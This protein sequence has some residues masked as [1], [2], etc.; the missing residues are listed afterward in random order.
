M[1]YGMFHK[2][3]PS[4]VA[5][6]AISKR[7]KEDPA[8]RARIGVICDENFAALGKFVEALSASQ[9]S[10][11]PTIT[12]WALANG[13]PAKPPMEELQQN[14]PRRAKQ[15]ADYMKSGW[16]KQHPVQIL[17]DNVEW[18]PK[19]RLVDVG[20]GLGQISIAL[21]EVLPEWSFVGHDFDSVIQRGKAAL[22]DSLKD[23]VQFMAYDFFDTQPVEG[24]DAYL[25]RPIFHNW[26]DNDCVKILQQLA[27]ALKR[28]A[29][30]ILNDFCMPEKGT[31][32][33]IEERI[34]RQVNTVRDYEGYALTRP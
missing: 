28:G 7:L 2:P 20:G 34:A 24:A 6:T 5:H 22:P 11:G 33:P 29:K 16:S 18:Q 27:P 1:T 10:K 9:D 14:H 32:T 26:S 25:F 8:L 12:A 31:L 30:I 15:L 23:R 21:A 19:G 3:R 4:V 17:K 13:S